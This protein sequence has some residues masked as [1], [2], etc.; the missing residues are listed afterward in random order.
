MVYYQKSP[1]H[2]VNSNR[3]KIVLPSFSKVSG[4]IPLSQFLNAKE[5]DA[6]R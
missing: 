4:G 1:V 6:K 5:F 2:T 3:F